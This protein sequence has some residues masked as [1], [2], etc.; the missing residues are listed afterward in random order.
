MLSLSYQIPHTHELKELK[1]Q[2]QGWVQP[3]D[4]TGW[5]QTYSFIE[6]TYW[7]PRDANLLW[8][9]L[10]PTDFNGIPDLCVHDGTT[11]WAKSYFKGTH[12]ISFHDLQAVCHSQGYNWVHDPICSSRETQPARMTM[13]MSYVMSGFYFMIAIESTTQ[14]I[15]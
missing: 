8:S 12:T 1:Q 13:Q 9:M 6:Q 2:F 10:N 7:N 3:Y 14:C 11:H 4:L 5:I 15:K